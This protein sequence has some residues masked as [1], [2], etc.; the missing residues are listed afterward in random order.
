MITNKILRN[1]T[2]AFLLSLLLSACAT[3]KK[4]DSQMQAADKW[5][6]HNHN[7]E[8]CHLYW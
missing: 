5:P 6:D 7:R 1:I 2:L 4:V 3:Q 8:P